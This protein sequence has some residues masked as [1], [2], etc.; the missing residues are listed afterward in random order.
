MKKTIVIAVLLWLV[1]FASAANAKKITILYQNDLHGW[2][3]PSSTRVGVVEL[4]GILTAVFEKN[5]NSF[6]AMSG[7]LFTGPNFEASSR[8][9]AELTLWNHFWAYLAKNGFGNRVLISAGNHDFDYG[10]PE[11]QAFASGLLCANMVNDKGLPYYT[12]WRVLTFAGGM[13]IGVVGLLLTRDRHVLSAVEQNRLKIVPMIKALSKAVSEMGMLDLTVLMIHDYI[14]PILRLADAI[15]REFGVDIILSGHEHILLNEPI[16]R[17]HIYI[18]QAGAMNEYYGRADLQV[19]D[20]R[21]VS[22]KNQLVPLF[23]SEL[24]RV[25]LRTKEAVDAR[26]GK[27]VA[28]LKQSLLGVCQG[29]RENSLGDFAADAYRWTTGTDV[30][31][32]NSASLRMNFRVCPDES[33]VLREGDFIT[34]NPFGDHLVTGE[35]TGEQL[36]QILEGDAVRFVNQVSGL[37][38]RSDRSKPEGKRISNIRI[39]GKFLKPDAVYTLTHNAYC[40]RPE[41]MKKYL[42]LEPGSVKWKKTRTLCHEALQNYAHHLKVID[43]PIKGLGRI[44]VVP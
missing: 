26:Q 19:E 22:L 3:F 18:F 39:N 9:K 24:G 13:R 32:I 34:M 2:L 38:Y 28:V 37:T 33:R 20:G 25:A 21:I 27:V 14:E 6:Y 35:V 44:E 7:D 17:N 5:P 12:P 30:A 43:Y 42:H 15:P 29:D 8:G 41:N 36:R 40:T 16:Q 11:P 23:P 4:A 31:M 10:V 1:L